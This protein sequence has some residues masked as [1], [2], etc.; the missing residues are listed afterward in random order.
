M[1]A[2]KDIQPDSY[3]ISMVDAFF[4]TGPLEVPP[5][6]INTELFALLE[7]QRLRDIAEGRT[8]FTTVADSVEAAQATL[9]LL[10]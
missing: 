8:T 7:A 9:R 6:D 2:A 1:S 3:Q 4:G 5:I 10:R